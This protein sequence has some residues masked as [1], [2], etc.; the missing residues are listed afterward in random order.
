MN[1]PGISPESHKYS[2]CTKNTES[3]ALRPGICHLQTQVKQHIDD[4]QDSCKSL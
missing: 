1:Q 4:L 2:L 3:L